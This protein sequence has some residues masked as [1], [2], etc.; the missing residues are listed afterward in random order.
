MGAEEKKR[1]KGKTKPKKNPNSIKL[2]IYL[3][4]IIK[5]IKSGKIHCKIS[6]GDKG[7]K[8]I[9]N[10]E[11]LKKYK[12]KWEKE[13]KSNEVGMKLKFTPNSNSILSFSCQT[14]M[15][16]SEILLRNNLSLFI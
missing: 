13:R 9:K 14:Q 16:W 11:N 7:K 4:K 3:L 15:K 6:C 1:E 8:I 2:F 10:Y 12:G 5:T